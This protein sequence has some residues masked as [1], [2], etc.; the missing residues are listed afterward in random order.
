MAEVP[1]LGQGNDLKPSDTTEDPVYTA[2][3]YAF[4][5]YA[6]DDGS[7]VMTPDVS[8]PIVTERE[9]T[10][11][12]VRNACETVSTDM[13]RQRIAVDV[14]NMTVGLLMQ[15]MAAAQQQAQAAKMA[16]GLGP[17]R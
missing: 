10:P 6:N 13:D 14:A 2:T 15:N 7:V 4:M 3:K 17:L 1:L 12:E 9:P 5:I 8:L 11:A 16:Q